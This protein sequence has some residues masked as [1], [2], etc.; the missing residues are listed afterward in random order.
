MP[1]GALIVLVGGIVSTLSALNA[2]TFAAS[3][4]SFAMGKQYNL[5]SFFSR[6]HTKYKTPFVSTIISGFIMLIM[7]LSLDLTEIAIAASVMFL[8]LFTQVNMASITI[9]RL[10]GKKLK[11]GFKTPFFPIFPIIG[12]LVAAGLAL[13]LLFTHPQ[14]WAIAIAWIALGFFIY[15]FYISKKEIEHYAPT[16]FNQGPEERKKFRIL[17]LYNKKTS[18]RLLKIADALSHEKEGEIS[19]LNVIKVPIQ[20]PLTLAQEFGESGMKSFD[21]F[22]KSIE[23]SIRHRYLVR[24][25][26]RR[27]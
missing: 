8:F 25:I 27:Y 23:H 9:R 17:V 10:Y 15:K 12:M 1:F 4:V 18:T 21:D 2:T 13:Y 14:S 16:V 26:S 20:V 11:Y 6:I 24:I 5:P 3:R 19:F 22:K 7:A